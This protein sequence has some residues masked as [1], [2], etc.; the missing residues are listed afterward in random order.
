MSEVKKCRKCDVDLI[1]E[2]T[3]TPGKAKKKDYICR[4]CNKKILRQWKQDNPEKIKKARK[5][6]R[7]KYK[8]K[9]QK[10]NEEYY[11]NNIIQMRERAKKYRKDNPEVVTAQ[12][13]R[14]RIK[15]KNAS[16]LGYNKEIR[17]IYKQAKEIEKTTGI[18]QHVDHIIPLSHS[19]VCG[20][21]VPWNLQI[22][23]AIENMKKSNKFKLKRNNND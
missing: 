12:G 1:V 22:I 19:D 7:I 4:D 16:I 11:N 21:H 17:Q 9:I 10:Y 15:K 8:E 3:W 14:K 5:N 2:E 6:L 18:P 23:P 20:L 13:A